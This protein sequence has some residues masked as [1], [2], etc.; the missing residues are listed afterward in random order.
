[1][2]RR[3]DLRFGLIILHTENTSTGWLSSV[4]TVALTRENTQIIC[5]LSKRD[6][7]LNLTQRLTIELLNE[8]RNWLKKWDMQV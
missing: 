1:M 2:I 5:N 4:K 6:K 8:Y 3:D 7:T